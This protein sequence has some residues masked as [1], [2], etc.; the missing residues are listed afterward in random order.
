MDQVLLSGGDFGGQTVEVE[1]GKME[2]GLTNEAGT[3]VF[4]Y[5]RTTHKDGGIY[6]AHFVRVEEL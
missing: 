6:T 5:N 3:H 2:F 4:Y 1:H